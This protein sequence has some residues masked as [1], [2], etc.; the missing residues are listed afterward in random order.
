MKTTFLFILLCLSS[1][2]IAPARAGSAGGVNGAT[3]STQMLNNIELA[4]SYAQQLQQYST[5]LQQYQAQL[6]NLERGSA[7]QIGAE[8]P[9]I[10]RGIGTIMAATN[11]IGG[12][13]ASIDSNFANTFKSPLAQ[14]FADRF[15]SL[16]T[17]SQ[18]TLGASA[19]A[20][21]LQRDTMEA[22]TRALE[23]AFAEVQATD[24]TVA[25]VQKLG[26]ISAQQVQQTQAMRELIAT[27]NIASSTWMAAQ[28]AKGQEKE[29][30]NNK[31]MYIAPRELPTPPSR[32]K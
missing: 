26:A 17:T 3:E 27:Q 9:G 16:T 29:D 28:D 7:G 18:A 15:K 1:F 14:N 21:G 30:A 20:A 5:Q 8:V 25:A 10:M 24:G 31:L 13:M 11:S 22:E 19:S 12:T 23:L 6:R 4:N 32:S 2:S